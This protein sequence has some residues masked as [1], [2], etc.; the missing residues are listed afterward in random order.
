VQAV[1]AA[2]SVLIVSLV[3]SALMISWSLPYLAGTLLL[4]LWQLSCAVRFLGD[5]SD[6]TA[7]RLLRASLLYLPLQFILITLLNLAII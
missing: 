2:A 1:V 4:G 6:G 5:R 7:R 3:P